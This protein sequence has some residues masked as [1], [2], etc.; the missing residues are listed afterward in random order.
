MAM[1]SISRDRGDGSGVGVHLALVVVQILFGLHYGAAKIVLAELP[2]R[3]WASLRAAGAALLLLALVR[4]TGRKLSG[5][6]RTLAQI[7]LLSLLGV[8]VNQLCFV[9]G[10]ARTTTL[11]SALI[12]T[13]IPVAT[14]LFA[15]TLGRERLHWRR[16]LAISSATLGVLF[17]IQP[18]AASSAP[19]MQIGDGLTL[20]NALSYALFLVL[21]KPTLDRADPLPATAALLA[22]GA[23]G[24]LLP[25]AGSLAATDLTQVQSTTWALAVGIIVGP[26]ALAYLLSYWALRRVD[27]S[28]VAFY[29]FLQPL[30]AVLLGILVLG[31]RPSVHFFV[32][33]LAVGLGVWLIAHPQA[34]V[35][36]IEV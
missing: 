2:P 21:S 18:W 13:T 23:V 27:A 20:L 6:H 3:A 25:G 29:V 10:L 28:A 5:G 24:L 30:L 19:A 35:G 36:S 8:V 7:A 34:K 26:T 15:A 33:A 4:A 11:H 14:L 9:E 22:C 31:E 17:I 1:R 16:I 12:N 32:G